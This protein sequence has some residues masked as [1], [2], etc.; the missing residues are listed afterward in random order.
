[1]I[2][3]LE[4][5]EITEASNQKVYK[6][7]KCGHVLGPARDDYKSFAKKRTVPVWK[8]EPEYLASFSKQSGTF[9]MREYYCPKCAVMFE[10]DMVH[11]DEPP[12]HSI[13][14]K[15]T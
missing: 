5:L 11:K 9:V 10:V 13:E 14:I 1:M 12:I 8:D 6:C 7:L 2:R 15:V 4:Y 3:I